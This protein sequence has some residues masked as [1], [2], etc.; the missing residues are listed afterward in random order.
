MLYHRSSFGIHFKYGNVYMP[1]PNSLTI[2]PLTLP[3]PVTISS[4]SI[5]NI[6]SCAIQWDL[7]VYLSYIYW[8]VFANPNSQLSLPQPLRLG[9]HTSVLYVC[10]SGSA[11]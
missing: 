2:P 7:I 10:E 3:P 8:L 5:F 11:L 1:I 6:A 4:F 9:N